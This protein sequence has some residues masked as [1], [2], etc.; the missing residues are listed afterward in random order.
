MA[1]TNVRRRKVR[2]MFTD[3][4]LDAVA[5]GGGYVTGILPGMK[6]SM[7]CEL[8]TEGSLALRPQ[9]VLAGDEELLLTD[10]DPDILHHVNPRELGIIPADAPKGG[11]SC[12]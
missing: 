3:A 12:S 10:P 6:V 2:P 4:Q 8:T 7:V 1:T 9:T 11:A 5:F